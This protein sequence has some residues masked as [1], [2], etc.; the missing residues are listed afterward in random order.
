MGNRLKWSELETMKHKVVTLIGSTKKEWQN[1]YRQ[2]ERELT[3]AGYVV[4]SVGL[5]KTDVPNIETYR[6]LLESIHFQKIDMADVVVLIDKKAEGE[7]TSLEKEHCKEIGKP[8]VTF[9][10]SEDCRKEIEAFNG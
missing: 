10:T 6:E 5:F 2:V 1:R 8:M 7:H 4:I 9:T 3:L